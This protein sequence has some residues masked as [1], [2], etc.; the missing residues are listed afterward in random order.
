MRS[1]YRSE[2][3]ATI[4]KLDL[5]SLKALGHTQDL[6]FELVINYVTTLQQGARSLFRRLHQLRVLEFACMTV[7]IQSPQ[8]IHAHEANLDSRKR[9]IQTQQSLCEGCSSLSTPRFV[10]GMNLEIMSQ[11]SMHVSH[12]F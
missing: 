2:I 5:H 11:R 12:I 1:A 4:L 8:A 10:A 7:E 3:L 6:L 9:A